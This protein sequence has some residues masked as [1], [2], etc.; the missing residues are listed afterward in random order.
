[1][2]G[3]S[4]IVPNPDFCRLWLVLQLFCPHILENIVAAQLQL[5]LILSIKKVDFA[6]YVSDQIHK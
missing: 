2:K 5:S 6:G 1:M 3:W 4:Y